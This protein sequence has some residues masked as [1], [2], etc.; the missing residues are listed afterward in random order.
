MKNKAAK[1]H[2]PHG[3]KRAMENQIPQA[4][5]GHARTLAMAAIAAGFLAGFLILY[6]QPLNDIFEKHVR[7]EMATFINWYPATFAF[8]N[9]LSGISLVAFS[10]AALIY[11]LYGKQA[12]DSFLVN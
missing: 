6:F 8:Y 2:R 10:F 3:E 4:R 7:S 1:K 9:R 11:V 12:I 5:A